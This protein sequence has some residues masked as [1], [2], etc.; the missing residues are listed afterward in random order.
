MEA[1]HAAFKGAWAN[2]TPMERGNC[3]NRLADLFEKH[4]EELAQLETLCSGK[5]IQ[6]SRF[7]E[8]GS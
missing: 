8:V 3:L 2:T 1:A 7:L 5:T 4:L 6:L